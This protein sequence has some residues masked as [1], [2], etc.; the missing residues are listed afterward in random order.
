MSCAAAA[1]CT[2]VTHVDC[3]DL[4]VSLSI[5]TRSYLSLIP[6]ALWSAGLIKVQ[7]NRSLEHVCTLAPFLMATILYLGNPWM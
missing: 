4:S 7:S 3:R 5:L 6:T 2:A 1:I